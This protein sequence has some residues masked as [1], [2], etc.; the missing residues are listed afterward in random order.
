LELV[1][2]EAD[3]YTVAAVLKNG[4]CEVTEFLEGLEE[5]YRGSADGLYALIGLVSKVG[6]QDISTK[7]SHCVNEEEKIY[8]FIK[9]KLRLFYFKGKGDLLV[10][11]TSGVIKKTQKVDE[12]QVTRAIA[13]KK[14]YL[15]SVKEGT[16]ELIK[17]NQDET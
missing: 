11:C 7:L 17:D 6:L 13:L 12:K 1:V 8:E 2:I 9:G 14:Q 5:T 4:N 15:Q 3:K 16:L 10:V